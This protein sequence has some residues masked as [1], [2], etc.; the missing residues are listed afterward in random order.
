[1]GLAMLRETKL[2]LR[3]RSL[4]LWMIFTL[5][6]SATAVW[7]GLNEVKHQQQSIQ[8]LLASDS[9][10][11]E[12]VQKSHDDWGYAA[13]YSFHL[14]HL[15]PSKFAFAALGQRD[16][17]PWKHRVRM[18]A[19]EGQ[20]YESDVSNPEL[21]LI[22]RFDFAF[23]AGFILPLILIVLL[24]DLRAQERAAGRH[25]LLEAT[26][27]NS[28]L[29]TIRATLRMLAIFLCVIIPLIIG[30]AV[31]KLGFTT[32]L[33][34][35]A[36]VLIYCVFWMLV[37]LWVGKK[38]F[39]APVLL[40]VLLGA[41]LVVSVIIP[42]AS[43]LAIDA[44]VPIPDGADILMTQRE[45]V[46]DSWDIPKKQ[47]MDFFVERNPQWSDYGEIKQQFQWKIYY[48]AQQVGDYKTEALTQKYMQGRLQRDRLATLAS[49]LS[50]P[51]LLQRSLQSLAG[52]DTRSLIGYEQSVRDFHAELRAFYYPKLF[53]EQAYDLS[54]FS[55]IPEFKLD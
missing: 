41:W 12:S 42:S 21:A 10:E 23:L 20:I 22:G 25:E 4:I 34:S 29:W 36:I 6:L 33:T 8:R 27:S 5:L 1:M 44:S 28:Q 17:M 2:M 54:K 26:S 9:Q 37:C 18:L 14:T 47:T 45:A 52:T 19:L 32:L 53:K 3:E 39:Q 38:N 51:A 50:P 13:Y 35:I 46:N 31:S 40:S 11:R 49:V 55:E 15:P 7:F 24:H 48:A 30:A 43:R 16:Q